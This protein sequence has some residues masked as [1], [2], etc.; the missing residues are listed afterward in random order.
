M[1]VWTV[2]W[3]PSAVVAVSAA[4]A[5]AFRP[6]VGRARSRA[7]APRASFLIHEGQRPCRG[8]RYR[9]VTEGCSRTSTK[10]RPAPPARGAAVTRSEL[11][12][13][14]L[15][16]RRLLCSLLLRGHLG[17]LPS[18]KSDRRVQRS[19]QPPLPPGHPTGLAGAGEPFL[20]LASRDAP[21]PTDPDRRN[22]LRV[23]VVHCAEAAQDGRGVDAQ[24]LGH[25]V[26]RQELSVV[27]QR[28]H[29]TSCGDSCYEHH[30]REGTLPALSTGGKAR[31]ARA[32]TR[33]ARASRAWLAGSFSQRDAPLGCGS[34]M[35]SASCRAGLRLD[36][37]T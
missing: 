23:R 30:L 21:D 13:L 36:R 25:L 14:R 2:V 27:R 18:S 20:E 10:V 24:A 15:F 6:T 7:S 16:L 33:R 29:C 8:R 4:A 37:P 9:I 28:G 32:R 35:S 22:A 31:R 11:L 5:R 1:S 19:E 3:V 26:G 12:L 34:G 17:H